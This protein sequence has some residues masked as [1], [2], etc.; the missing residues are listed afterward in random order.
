MFECSEADAFHTQ[1]GMDRTGYAL[2][3]HMGTPLGVWGG[4][5]VCP[6]GRV[7]QVDVRADSQ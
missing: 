6:S 2:G 7:Y 1:P 4:D 3:W 5:C